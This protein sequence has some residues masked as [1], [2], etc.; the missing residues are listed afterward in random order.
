MSGLQ[1]SKGE[2]TA[3]K[4][5]HAGVDDG[6][7]VIAIVSPDDGERAYTLST[8]SDPSGVDQGYQNAEFIRGCFIVANQ[9]GLTPKQ[10]L[11]Q[12]DELLSS[13]KL[14]RDTIEYLIKADR[15]AGD[16]EGAR[17]KSFTLESV[18]ELIAKAEGQL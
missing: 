17:L 2:I 16:D 8:P 3:A 18:E 14:F 13:V 1:I 11:E 12:R 6:D 4:V 15:V 7:Y 5:K 10:L 9:T